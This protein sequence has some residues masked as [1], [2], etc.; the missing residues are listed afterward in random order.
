MIIKSSD[1]SRLVRKTS[2]ANAYDVLLDEDVTVQP[3]YNCIDLHLSVDLPD[4]YC[5]LVLTR[6]SNMK[7]G[8]LM[9]STLVDTDY[10][11]NLHA[12]FWSMSFNNFKK[13]DRICQFLIIKS[14]EVDNW[15]TEDTIRGTGGLGSTK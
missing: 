5:I 14:N 11:G 1:D 9:P 6:S 4:N 3:G 13:G 7:K 10:K 2:K 12:I 15:I 8:I